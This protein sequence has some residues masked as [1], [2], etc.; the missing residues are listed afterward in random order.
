MKSKSILVIDDEVSIRKF[1]RIGL[2]SQQFEVHE[3]ESGQLGIQEI[4]ARK[5]DLV[6]LD[7]GLT[8]MS[9]QDVIVKVREWSQVPI[10]VLTV[11]DSEDD[12]VLA[13]DAGADDYLT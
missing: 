13:L 2:E 9:G 6:I 1:L 4:V 11:Q 5:P 10:V 3:A 7:L 12:K 8:D